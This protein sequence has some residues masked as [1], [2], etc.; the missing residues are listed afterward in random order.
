MNPW[1]ILGWLFLILF[2]VPVVGF[3]L[4]VFFGSVYATYSYLGLYGIYKK[5]MGILPSEGEL[6]NSIAHPQTLYEICSVNHDETRKADM[7]KMRITREG[8]ILG[9]RY[10][11]IELSDWEHFKRVNKLFL[12]PKVN[13]RL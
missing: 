6:W 5:G 1:N 12:D 7:V 13:A 2:G 3:L 10:L 9:H 11:S 4:I 8:Q